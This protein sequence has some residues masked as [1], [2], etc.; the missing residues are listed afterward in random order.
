MILSQDFDSFKEGY[1]TYS[2]YL[3]SRNIY[4]LVFHFNTYKIGEGR[5]LLCLLCG[6]I[7]K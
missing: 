2:I 3:N 4:Q 5:K 7:E 1:I 6:I